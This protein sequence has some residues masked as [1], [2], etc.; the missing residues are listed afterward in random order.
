[1]KR[2][3]G[4]ADGHASLLTERDPQGAALGGLASGHLQSIR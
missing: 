1:M 4:L 2:E 3:L